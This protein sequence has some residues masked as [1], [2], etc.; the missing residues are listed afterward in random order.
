MDSAEREDLGIRTPMPRS[1]VESMASCKAER[2][3]LG[4]MLGKDILDYYFLAKEGEKQKLA[5][6]MPNGGYTTSAFLICARTH[7][8][9]SH[10]TRPCADPINV[11][12]EFMRRT[13]VGPATF[14]VRDVKIGARIS[15]LHLTLFQDYHNT[16]AGATHTPVVEG[17][18]TL[19]NIATESGLSLDT[20]YTPLPPPLP[21]DLQRLS[22]AAGEDDNYV[23]RRK[24]AYPDFRRA[25]LCMQMYL[26]KPDRWPASHPLSINDQ[27][28]RFRPLQRE[29]RWTN[30]ALGFVVDM[31]PQVVEKYINP[32][33]ERAAVMEKDDEKLKQITKENA[34]KA[35]YWYPTMTLNLDVKKLLPEEGVEW[36]FTRTKAK[37]I[38]NGR[39]DLDVEVWDAQGELVAISSHSSLIVDTSRNTTRNG[40]KTQIGKL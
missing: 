33:V 17:Y 9:L 4:T 31:F 7:M 12:L 21:A 26:V 3:T 37:T 5:N 35:K 29:G 40:K 23:L 36:L 30:D 22:S 25:T 20:S 34:K 39:L 14:S 10:P 13:A 18:I 16:G 11:H 8:Q 15:N 2:D 28:S 1:L 38:K 32:S 19:S 27:W 6:L 24:E